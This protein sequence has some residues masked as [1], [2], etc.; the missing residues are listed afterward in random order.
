VLELALEVADIIDELS[1]ISRLLESQQDTLGDT[2][3]IFKELA[4]RYACEL[5][6]EADLDLKSHMTQITRMRKD[7]ERSYKSVSGHCHHKS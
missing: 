1:I 6:A 7:A 2:I 5:L 4:P 3:C